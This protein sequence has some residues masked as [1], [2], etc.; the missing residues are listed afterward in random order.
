MKKHPDMAHTDGNM[1]SVAAGAQGRL[2][3]GMKGKVTIQA[4]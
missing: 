2:E 3:A 4:N 1:T